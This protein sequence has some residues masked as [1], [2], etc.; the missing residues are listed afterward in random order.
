MERQQEKEVRQT[1]R[2]NQRQTD[3]K[4]KRRIIKIGILIFL[5]ILLILILFRC[6][7]NFA[8]PSTDSRIEQGIIDL[9]SKK[10][11][12]QL[13]NDAVEQG[14]FQVFMNTDITISSENEANL[15][16]QNNES[17]PYPAYVE[18]YKDKE[19]LYKSDIIP[20]GYKLEQDKLERDLDPGIYNC[21]AYFHIVNTTNNLEINKISLLVKL[22]KE[23]KDE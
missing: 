23:I 16:I 17:N 6:S 7:Y 1:E 11:A 21:T 4:A 12:Q 9:I 10:E 18:I 5:I 20:P 13:V 8:P 22:T 14:M 19:L 15:L 3:K 2:E